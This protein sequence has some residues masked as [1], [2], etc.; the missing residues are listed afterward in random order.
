[1]SWFCNG[2]IRII[3]NGICIV[4]NVLYF[5]EKNQQKICAYGGPFDGGI[6]FVMM[7][8]SRMHPILNGVSCLLV[9]HGEDIVYAICHAFK[10][11]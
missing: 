8:T 9:F 10:C 1:M 2:G 5:K 11:C 7:C 4:T 3:I 6:G